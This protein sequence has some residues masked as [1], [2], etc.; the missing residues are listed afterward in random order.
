MLRSSG[1]PG[2]PDAVAAEGVR[3]AAGVD[4]AAVGL[5]V[6]CVACVVGAV[7][8]A[9]AV[10]AGPVVDRDHVTVAEVVARVE[11]LDVRAVAEVGAAV[12]TTVADGAGLV[13]VPAQPDSPPIATTA[14][15]TAG[16]ARNLARLAG[17]MRGRC[18]Y[19]GGHCRATFTASPSM[20]HGG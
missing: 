4:V 14:A 18:R 7:G 6:A 13:V 10:G 19:R 12:G 20:T 16:T 3:S 8:V 9:G 15:V 5:G 1:L 17:P 2:G 11:T